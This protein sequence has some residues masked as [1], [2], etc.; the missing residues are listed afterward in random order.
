VP[1][2][3]FTHILLIALVT[4]SMTYVV[5]WMLIEP[6]SMHEQCVQMDGSVLCAVRQALIMGFVWNLYAFASVMLGIAAL[7]SSSRK[8]AWAAV[9][10]GVIGA[11]LYRVEFAALGLLL[12][13][14]VL[15]RAPMAPQERQSHQ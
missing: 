9:V 10:M 3:R 15:A 4:A 2:K 6:P 7:L 5:R 1:L 13:A 14:L 11:M 8:C 12:G